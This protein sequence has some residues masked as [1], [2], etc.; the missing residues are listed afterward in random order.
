MELGYIEQ[1]EFETLN[2]KA[3]AISKMLSGFINY[4][5]QSEL[6]GTKFITARQHHVHVFEF[7]IFNFEF[8]FYG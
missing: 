4:L 2:E 3:T 8:K 1:Q 5:K 6:K 7:L